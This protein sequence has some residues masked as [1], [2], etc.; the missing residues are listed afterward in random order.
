M[1]IMIISSCMYSLVLVFSEDVCGLLKLPQDVAGQVG[2]Y[3]SSESQ[4]QKLLHLPTPLCQE[5]Q[6]EAGG[7]R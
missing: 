5:S 7:V 1:T 6:A 2:V 4:Q 3:S